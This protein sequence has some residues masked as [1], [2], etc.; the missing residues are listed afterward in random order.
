MYIFEINPL[1]VQ[2]ALVIRIPL[3]LRE[4]EDPLSESLFFSLFL[5]KA[6]IARSKW[7]NVTKDQAVCLLS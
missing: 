7:R 5:S 1:S 3:G 6:D 2:Q 4:G